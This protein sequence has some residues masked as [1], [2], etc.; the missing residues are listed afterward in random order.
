MTERFSSEKLAK[1]R[2]I[3][4][5]A[6]PG[7]WEYNPHSQG[8]PQ[9]GPQEHLI[10]T[11]SESD[12]ARVKFH[13][14]S[15]DYDETGYRD[16][17]HIAAFDPDTVLALLA[18]L[19]EY[20]KREVQVSSFDLD[21]WHCY[22]VASEEGRLRNGAFPVMWVCPTCGNKRCPKASHHG[23]TC[24]GSNEP[25]QIGSVYGSDQDDDW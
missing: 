12:D 19:E 6:T 14:A 25:G 21:C 1:L 5:K 4:S 11:E 17:E 9:D 20:R 2:E 16:A 15:T 13:I 18:E 3:A 8:N 24:T 7:G 10:W 23:N 22:R